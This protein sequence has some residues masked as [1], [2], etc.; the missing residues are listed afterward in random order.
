MRC[1][2]TAM[3]S[4]DIQYHLSWHFPSLRLSTCVHGTA[5]FYPIPVQ[6]CWPL[7]LLVVCALGKS[8]TELL[9]KCWFPSSMLGLVDRSIQISQTWDY[10]VTSSGSNCLAI[11][12]EDRRYWDWT[13]RHRWFD[14][15]GKGEMEHSHPRSLS[16]GALLSMDACCKCTSGMVVVKE[17]GNSIQ[18]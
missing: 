13:L 3:L 7:I 16:L 5:S 14:V 10:T 17:V 9:L 6:W 11:L 15:E 18:S 2:C 4:A 12:Q 8:W 1:R